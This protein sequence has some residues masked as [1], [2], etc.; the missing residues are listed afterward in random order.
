MAKK[1]DLKDAIR[2][3]KFEF[4]LLQKIPC[5]KQENKEYQKLQKEGGV[6]PDGVYAYN[7]YGEFPEFYT[8]YKQ[9]LTE[10]EVAEYLTFEKLKLIRTIKKCVMFFTIIAIIAIISAVVYLLITMNALH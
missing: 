8:I 10:S 5:S 2:S 3:Y 9:D 7:Y 4:N 6:L 1:I